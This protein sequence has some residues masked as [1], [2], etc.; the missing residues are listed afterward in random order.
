MGISGQLL[1]PSLFHGLDWRAV[2]YCV[3]SSKQTFAIERL[4]VV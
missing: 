1:T 2:F 3:S 4:K